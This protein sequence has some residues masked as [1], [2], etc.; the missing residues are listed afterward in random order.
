[1]ADRNVRPTGVCFLVRIM[2]KHRKRRAASSSKLVAFDNASPC[3]IERLEDRQLL[4]ATIDL[5]TPSGGKTVNVTS[6]GQVVNLDV[7]AIVTGSDSTAVNDAFQWAHGSFLSTD[8]GG[9]AAGGDFSASVA[10]PFNAAA[11]FNGTQTDLG[12]GGGLDVGGND[13]SQPNNYFISRAG[14]LQGGTHP[15]PAEILVWAG[16][17]SVTS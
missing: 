8:V 4:S 3:R 7:W 2:M 17:F 5:R 6:V 10:S 16:S 11:A 15:A 9:G 14:G 1:M 13:N 12:G